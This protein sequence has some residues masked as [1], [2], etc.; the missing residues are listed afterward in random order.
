M[1][2][3]PNEWYE[4]WFDTIYYHI[5]YKKRDHAEAVRF[6]DNLVHYL[7]SDKNSMFLDLACG[8][9]RHSIY[10]NKKGYDV[11]GI[12][13][14]INNISEARLS[15]SSSLRF[16]EHDM[17]EPLPGMM[18][19]Y[20]LNLFTS[21]GYFEDPSDDR[22]VIEMVNSCLNP[23]GVFVLDYFNF[24]KPS[25]NFDKPFSKTIDSVCFD[26]KKHIENRRIIKEITVNDNDKVFHFAEQVRIYTL[27]QFRQMLEEAGFVIH[28]TFGN[29]DLDPYLESSSDR[30]ILVAKH[31]DGN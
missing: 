21:F 28:A 2:D 13:L 31:S 4:D 12:D 11:T 27:D 5:L 19:D 29:Y 20:V 30:L 17:R 16:F 14:S 24:G 10:L 3:K 6:I 8:K 22:A 9:G 18:F 26:I 15:A 7:K 25:H 23:N 1:A